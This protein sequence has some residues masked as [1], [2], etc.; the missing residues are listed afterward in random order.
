MRPRRIRTSIALG[1][2]A[3]LSGAAMIAPGQAAGGTPAL[4]GTASPSSAL[5]LGSLLAP[6]SPYLNGLL[7]SLTGRSTVLIHGDRLADAERA[8]RLSGMTRSTSFGKIGV[9]ALLV[10]GQLGE[11]GNPVVAGI[12]ALD[13]AFA[14]G[15]L[16]F[17]MS[18]GDDS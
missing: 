6:V 18:R 14:I 11:S 17:L 5:G 1:A 4:G 3:L 16:A 2:A 9:V 8:V 10:P 13:A 12:L 15:F 7:P